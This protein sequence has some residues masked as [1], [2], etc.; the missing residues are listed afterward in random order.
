MT[1]TFACGQCGAGLAFEGVRTAR[2]PYC[3][4]PS[5]VERP[6]SPGQPD[7]AFV[8][9]FVGDAKVARYSL[10]RWLGS[11][12]MFADSALKGAK[13]EDLRGI[14][15]PSYL[16]SAVGST[17]YSAQ[18]GENYT[19]TETYT[20]TENGKTVTRTRT[21]TRTEYRSLSGRHVG[22][23][24]DVVVSASAGL[25]NTELQRIEPFD[26]RL[27][28]R[29][30]PALITGWIAEEYSRPAGECEKT[31]RAEA[32]DVIGTKLR[33]F[34][35][36]DSY[37]DLTYRTSVSWESLDP[38]LVPVWVFAVRYRDDKDPLRVV[39][40]GQTGKI[41]GKV[42]LSAWKIVVTILLVLAIIAGVIFLGVAR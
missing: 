6:A 17:E 22:Y 9:T 26:V 24:T 10:D 39:I 30:S 29:F 40:N 42:P 16:Y 20:T 1:S 25:S 7:P 36:G 19:E 13:V 41:S 28:R 21:V 11:R 2:C 23:V 12:T 37:S 31:S 27:M 3:D 38:I 4:S 33:S 34:M 35:P 5:F 14:Y 32:M 8:L 18:I 15:V